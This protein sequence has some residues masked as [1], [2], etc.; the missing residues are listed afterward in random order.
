VDTFE[1]LGMALGRGTGA[2]GIIPTKAQSTKACFYLFIYLFV[3]L[4][5]ELRALHL[6]SKSSTT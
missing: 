2:G 4:G 1:D 6:L 3:I 5:I